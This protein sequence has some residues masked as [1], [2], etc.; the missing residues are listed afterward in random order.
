MQK[1][2]LLKE[3]A[4]DLS[5]KSLLLQMVGIARFELATFCPP[6]KRAKPS[7]AI[8]R[9]HEINI[10]SIWKIAS[11]FI[12]KIPFFLFLSIVKVNIYWKDADCIFSEKLKRRI[13]LV[14]RRFV[15][16]MSRKSN[17]TEIRNWKRPE[18]PLLLS[19]QQKQ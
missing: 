2:R 12:K 4:L 17:K 15:T 5:Q 8:S 19:V 11:L 14:H 10:L 9:S 7:C 6:D 13:N 1:K 16:K 18:L 3:V